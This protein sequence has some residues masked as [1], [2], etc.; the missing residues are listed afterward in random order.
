MWKLNAMKEGNTKQGVDQM[1][2]YGAYMGRV[3]KIDLSTQKVSE[4]PWTDKDRH[5]TIGGKIMAGDILYHHIHPGMTAF[6]EDN[7]IVIT[8]GPLTGTGAPSSSRFNISTI[9]P[10]TGNITSSNSGGDFGLMLKRCGYDGCIIT[11]RAE[12]PIHI[13]ITEDTVKFNDASALWGMEC[14]P[15]QEKLPKGTGKLVIGPAGENKVLY[16]AVL[17]GERCHGRGGVGA[18]FGDKNIKAITAKG[19][20]HP[21]IRHEEKIRKKNRKWCENMRKHALTG[22]QVPQLGTA[23]LVSPMQAR[24]ILAT[25]NFSRGQFDGF[26]KVSGETLAETRLLRNSGCTTCV[27]QCTRRCEVDGK[28]VKGPEL[29]ILGLMGPNIL[30]EDLDKIIQWNYEI[31]ELG[32]DAISCS[33]S[34]AFAM[35]LKEKGLWDE[36]E[37]EFGKIDNVSEVIRKIAFREGVGDE[38]ANGSKKMAEK[39]G[40][41][42]FAINVKG[43]ELSAYEPRAAFGQGLGYATSNRGGCHLNAGYLVFVEGLGLDVN[44]LTPHGKADLAVMFQNLMEAISAAGSCLF[45]S[46]AVFPTLVFDKPNNPITK[47]VNGAFPYLGPVLFLL[48]HIYPALQ[49]HLF[50]IPHTSAIS[51][52][53]GMKMTLGDFLVAGDRGWNTERAANIILGQKP[54]ADTLPK[55]LTDEKQIPGTEKSVPLKEMLK[56]FYMDRGWVAGVPTKWKLKSLGI[57]LPDP[58]YYPYPKM[59]LHPEE[60]K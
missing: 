45:T 4:F 26:D 11:G 12:K 40:G 13:E 31:D 55:R 5:R 58:A 9:S 37:L 48:N 54:G 23:G 27:I 53:S 8:T 22:R 49:M 39:F 3:L 42:E 50:L 14:T 21:E 15:A 10:L 36:G 33:G 20:K 47:V 43:M 59:T 2:K 25:K 19:F 18:V 17:S 32:M 28:D 16:A 24:N 60:V 7:W 51:K 35:E 56:G 52:A 46:Y 57:D 30:N 34:I 38:I 1:T 44:G 6:D 29:E 41:E